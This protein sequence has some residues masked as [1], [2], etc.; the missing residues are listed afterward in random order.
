MLT[1]SNSNHLTFTN[2]LVCP[3]RHSD[4]IV[5]IYYVDQRSK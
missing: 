5:S 3:N 2:V 1:F 4:K